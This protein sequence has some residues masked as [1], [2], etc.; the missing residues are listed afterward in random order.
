MHILQVIDALMVGGTERMLVDISN[1]LTKKGLR[2]SVCVTRTEGA[3]KHYLNPSIN[4]YCLKRESRFDLR[5]LYRFRELIQQEKPDI[6]HV[7]GRSTCALIALYC[8]TLNIRIPLVF[9]DHYGLIY[10]DRTIPFWFKL[11]GKKLI[12]IYIGVSEELGKW[13]SDTGYPRENIYVINNSIDLSRY[14]FNEDIPS[15]RPFLTGLFVA[16]IRYEKGLHL[17]IET[18]SKIDRKEKIKFLIVGGIR[19][20]EYYER[21]K[22]RINEL[23]VKDRFE[24]I[25]EQIDVANFICQSDFGVSPSV[26]ES[27]P[28]VLIEYIASGLPV[29]YTRVGE[30]SNKLLK[31]HVPGAI[32]PDDPDDLICEMDRLI[33]LSPA[34]FKERGKMGRKIAV[35]E[36]DINQKIDDF[37]NVYYSAFKPPFVS[38]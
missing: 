37:I 11:Y 5:G 10:V 13:A 36:F 22:A 31:L 9:Q 35:D 29:I 24:F 17:L 20:Q 21:C 2:V 7:H 25:G 27:G 19:D 3:L 32:C 6:L 15:N 16:G 28:L 26:S 1:A 30:I 14:R 38:N 8:I 23:Q 34:E 33:D 18:V 4:T 12:Q